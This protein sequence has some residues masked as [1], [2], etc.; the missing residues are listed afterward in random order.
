[1]HHPDFVSEKRVNQNVENAQNIVLTFGLSNEL[2]HSL[3]GTR[4]LSIGAVY[5][6]FE[7]V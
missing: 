7:V 4:Q 1:M 2:L 5:T 3:H 6:S